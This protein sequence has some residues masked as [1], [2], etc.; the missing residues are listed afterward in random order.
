[1]VRSRHTLIDDANDLADLPRRCFD[2]THRRDR[3]TDDVSAFVR[4]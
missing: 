2:A 4:I 1:L 3:L